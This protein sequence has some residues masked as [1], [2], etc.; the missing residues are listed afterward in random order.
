MLLIL[1]HKEDLFSLNI[2]CKSKLDFYVCQ[3]VKCH[4]FNFFVFCVTFHTCY[5]MKGYLFKLTKAKNQ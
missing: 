4:R 5:K 3:Q 1:M 2:L